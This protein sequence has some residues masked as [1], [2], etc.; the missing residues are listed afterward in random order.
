MTKNQIDLKVRMPEIQTIYSLDD[1]FEDKNEWKYCIWMTEWLKC[2]R[3]CNCVDR[4][5]NDIK[6]KA[7]QKCTYDWKMEIQMNKN[8]NDWKLGWKIFN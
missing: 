3:N 2:L 7:G 5:W 8:Q 6:I 1:Y 4:Y